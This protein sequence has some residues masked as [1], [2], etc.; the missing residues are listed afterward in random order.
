VRAGASRLAGSCDVLVYV[1]ENHPRLPVGLL[2]AAWAGV[3]FVPV[4]YRLDDK[5]LLALVER[6]PGALILADGPTAHR[7]H[8]ATAPVVVFDDWL[9]E[10]PVE[11]DAAEPPVDD[12][13]VAIILYTSGT[14]SEPKAALLG[15]RHLMAYRRTTSPAWRT[16]SGTCSPAAGS[17]ICGRSMRSHG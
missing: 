1:G 10:L 6:Q 17:S 11:S 9:A 2:S 8:R 14:T 5:R 15:H 13:D 16:C 12:D 7:L 4:N 3:P